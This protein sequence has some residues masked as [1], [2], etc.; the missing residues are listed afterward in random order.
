MSVGVLWQDEVLRM[1]TLLKLI[2]DFGACVLV[3]VANKNMYSMLE[4]SIGLNTNIH[5]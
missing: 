3:Q 4:V 5:G 1:D 2:C